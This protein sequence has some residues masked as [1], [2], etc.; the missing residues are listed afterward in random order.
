MGLL[1]QVQK[2]AKPNKNHV[3]ETAIFLKPKK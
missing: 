3:L 2:L 1:S